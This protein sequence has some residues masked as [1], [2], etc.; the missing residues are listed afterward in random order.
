MLWSS[1]R[2][3]VGSFRILILRNACRH[4]SISDIVILDI[5]MTMSIVV[6]APYPGVFEC[7]HSLVEK[8]HHWA[9]KLD[10]GE[11][12]IKRRWDGVPRMLAGTEVW[13]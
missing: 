3:L 7:W 8:C 12:M 1:H 4:L 13:V 6:E 10:E 9:S 2:S 5:H 11:H